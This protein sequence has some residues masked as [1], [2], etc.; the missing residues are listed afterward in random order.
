MLTLPAGR[1]IAK[2][3]QALVRAYPKRIALKLFHR[4]YI[5]IGNSYLKLT[6]SA[7][8]HL[9]YKVFHS[10]NINALHSRYPH[11]LIFIMQ[12]ELRISVV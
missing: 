1:G 6:F 7:V 8:S 12:K 4:P 9:P 5:S 11:A 2:H 3:V 10:G